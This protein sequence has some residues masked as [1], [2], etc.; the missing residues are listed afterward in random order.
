[1]YHADFKKQEC[2]ELTRC[3]E[4]LAIPTFLTLRHEYCE[5]EA[6]LASTV[7]SYLKGE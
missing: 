5:F 7:I 6:I 4:K 3:G 1:M 2:W